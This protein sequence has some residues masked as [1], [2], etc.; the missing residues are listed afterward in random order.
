MSRSRH[1][2]DVVDVQRVDPDEGHAGGD[3]RLARI[4]R[5]ERVG[6]E[7]RVGPPVTRELRADKERLAVSV[8]SGQGVTANRSPGDGDVGN[9][10]RQVCE[11]RE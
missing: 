11:A 4:G 6:G 5:Q 10:H 7:V 9:D 2:A 1:V 3:K 8:P